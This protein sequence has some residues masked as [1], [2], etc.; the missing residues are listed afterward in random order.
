MLECL[1]FAPICSLHK[2]TYIVINRLEIDE[3]KA[4]QYTLTEYW[5][6]KV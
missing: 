2:L 5:T 4:A 6:K 3:N 1:L